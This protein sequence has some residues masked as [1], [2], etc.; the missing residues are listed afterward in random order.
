MRLRRVEIERFRG[1]KKLDWIVRG[2]F[3]CLVGP[4]DS[5]KT[6]ILDAIECALTPRWN[7][8]FDDADFYEADTKEPFRIE[9]TVGDLPDDLKAESKWGYMA[10]GWSPQ[11]DLHDEPADTDEL[12]LSIRLQVDD[13]LEPKWTV[14]NDRELQGRPISSKDREKL[15]CV[16]VG[17]FMDRHFSW[18]R[19]SILSR[20]TGDTDSIAATLAKAGRAARSAIGSADPEQLET[21]RKAADEAHRLGKEFGVSAK[22]EYRPHLDVETVSVGQGGLSLHD[23]EVPLRHAGMGTRRLL[24]VAMQLD[25]G[26][27][28]GLTL[29]DEV[30]HGLEP[31]RLRH[32]LRALGAGQE[33]KRHV[34]MTTHAPTVL[35][36]LR[37]SQLRVVRSSAG[38]TEVH[39]IPDSLQRHVRKAAGA[40]LARKVIVCEGRTEIGVCRAFDESWGSEDGR[41]F[42]LAGIA[43]VDGGGSDAPGTASALADLGYDVMLLADTDVPFSPSEDDMRA[44]GIKVNVW[45]DGCALEVRVARDLSWAGVAEV[46]AKAMELGSEEAVRNAVARRAGIEPPQLAAPPIEWLKCGISEAKLREAVGNAAK[47]DK[48]KS[49]SWFKRVD[50]AEELGKT[51]VRHKD[52]VRDKDLGKKLFNVREWA[53]GK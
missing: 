42:G 39:E 1:I 22:H 35:E 10:R 49:K 17:D 30:E 7:L 20:L 5:T 41:S 13:S 27:T 19:G 12:V 53:H 24:A 32:A 9:V 47:G 40:F 36:E 52:S 48:G 31:H 15:S 50:L 34:L 2:D 38:T 25:T 44:K 28:G 3:V 21:L 16:R 23:G 51:L 46:I 45:A 43:L 18:G 4:G 29:I 33:A 26:G 11:G 8:P 6:T 14:F 37:A